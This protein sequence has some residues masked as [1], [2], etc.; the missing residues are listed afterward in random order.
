MMNTHN[1]IM[2]VSHETNHDCKRAQIIL[3]GAWLSDLGFSHEMLVRCSYSSGILTMKACGIGM[4]IYK[5]LVYELRKNKQHLCQVLEQTRHS[6]KE[7]YLIIG[8]T[9]LT[10]H[11]FLVGDVILCQ[12]EKSVIQFKKVN[13]ETLGFATKSNAIYKIIQ[14]QKSSKH[15]RIVTL[16]QC[17]G[18]WLSDFGFHTYDSTLVTYE[19]DGIKFLACKGKKRLHTTGGKPIHIN[20]HQDRNTPFF[21][22]K[23]AWLLDVGFQIGDYLIVQI[24]QGVIYLKRFD[25][26]HLSFL[27]TYKE[28]GGGI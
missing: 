22:L 4:D 28:Q 25:N 6:K 14:V 1:R 9:W 16:I 19:S 26:D 7:P 11:G 21:Q 8:G 13:L 5:Q 23:G 12:A 20:I 3:K 24:Q 18:D 27:G 10:R 2:S 17:K 15:G